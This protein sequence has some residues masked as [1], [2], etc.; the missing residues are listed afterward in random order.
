MSATLRLS[1]T[2]VG[3]LPAHPLMHLKCGILEHIEQWLWQDDAGL[4]VIWGILEQHSEFL[5]VWVV[6]HQVLSL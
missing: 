3:D 5:Q 4:Y 6:L 2:N 1:V